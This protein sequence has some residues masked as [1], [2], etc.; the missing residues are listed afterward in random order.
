MPNKSLERTARQPAC[1]QTCAGLP[2]LRVA[3]GQPLNSGVRLLLSEVV[4]GKE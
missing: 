3:G 4:K 1:Y 2:K